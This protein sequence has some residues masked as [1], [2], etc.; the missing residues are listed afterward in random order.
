MPFTAN[1][2]MDKVLT[3]PTKIDVDHYL[4]Q[5]KISTKI[6]YQDK[7]QDFVNNFIKLTTM[8]RLYNCTLTIW[9]NLI[10]LTSLLNI[11]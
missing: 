4:S 7:L 3:I 8:L 6:S 9:S 11:H 10:E 5:E 1:E 2:I